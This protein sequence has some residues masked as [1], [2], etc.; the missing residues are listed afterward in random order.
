MIHHKEMNKRSGVAGRKDARKSQETERPSVRIISICVSLFIGSALLLVKYN[1][2]YKELTKST[3]VLIDALE[4]LII[5]GILAHSLFTYVTKLLFDT[6][7]LA[8]DEFGGGEDKVRLFSAGFAGTL[9]FLSAASI[10]FFYGFNQ[11]FYPAKLFNLDNGLVA[12]IIILLAHLAW[13]GGLYVFGTMIRSHA[14]VTDAETVLT[15]I[16][17]L[18]AAVF[19]VGIAWL[20]DFHRIDGFVCCIL[21][22]HIL[23]K[24]MRL[25]L[26]PFQ[27][28]RDTTEPDFLNA[29]YR[30]FNEVR[31]DIWIDIHNLRTWFKDNTINVDFH[32]IMPRDITLEFA[33]K[34]QEEISKLMDGRFGKRARVLVHIEPC[35]ET[36][37]PYC[38]RDNCRMRSREKPK[39]EHR[40]T[41]ATLTSQYGPSG[42]LKSKEYEAPAHL[43]SRAIAVADYN[44]RLLEWLFDILAVREL[45]HE[46]ILLKME[47]V[48]IEHR[49]R[50]LAEELL[51]QQPQGFQRMLA[52]IAIYHLP[53]PK[54]AITAVC[55]KI[56]R[57]D[58]YL[59][60]AVL[61]GLIEVDRQ[62][63]LR[64]YRIPPHLR[65]ILKPYGPRDTEA[66]ARDAV[67][68][69]YHVWWYE[70]SDYPNEN[71]ALEMLRLATESKEKGIAF[72][73]GDFLTSRWIG[74]G[75]IKEALNLCVSTM[76]AVG[77]DY[78][79]LR[80]MASAE[81][82]MKR[83]DLALKH[84]QQAL[85]ICPDKEELD[86]AAILHNMAVIYTKTGH[87]TKAL[88]LF[89][90]SLEIK[91]SIDNERGMS[92]TLTWI[93]LIYSRQNKTNEA[94]KLYEQALDI[95]ERIGD[96]K[97]KA[98]TL[99]QMAAVYTKQN[100]FEE[101]LFFYQQAY[102]V[103][104]KSGSMKDKA[105]LINQMAN[106]HMKQD[107]FKEALTLYKQL[108]EIKRNM[109][110]KKGESEA[111]TLM[112]MLSVKMLKSMGT[113]DTGK[114]TKFPAKAK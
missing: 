63:S 84:Y 33:H 31:K 34:E 108:R 48:E 23:S 2:V 69:L 1:Y 15:G 50:V 96:D 103:V 11:L 28:F 72:E 41:L 91:E 88:T 82:A 6:P 101:A 49:S 112:S 107:R 18:A 21:G 22:L 98:S 32:M 57:L 97:G 70:A 12:L 93:A 111:V 20:T 79:L 60:L 61:L 83:S 110:D 90:R 100:L 78:R 95:Q 47:G 59:D 65:T 51:K 29:V 38:S 62:K 37:C 75:R 16:W 10:L 4:S 86:K 68:N 44:T 94:L 109:G 24:G 36:D 19:A 13:A 76:K 92:S 9:V 42:R 46:A 39:R 106:I 56:T 54:S 7:F 74:M 26:M 66:L 85:Q 105:A 102:E 55:Y 87:S 43:M 99:N 77:D 113:P 17:S 3:A 30:L 67:L 64:V 52:F 25:I 81:K 35:V 58:D 71:Q 8:D 53:V 27:G 80:N 14:L 45:N 73:I 89:H 104:I 5:L 40:W 114:V